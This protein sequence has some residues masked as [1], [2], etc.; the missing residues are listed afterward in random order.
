MDSRKCE[1][2]EV[3]CYLM[4]SLVF[5]VS[6]QGYVENYITGCEY[7]RE[8]DVDEYRCTN[9]GGLWTVKQKYDPVA[10]AETWQKVLD[11]LARKEVV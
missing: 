4:K 10:R 7:D 5:T 2:A 9:C 11:H 8:S 6:E 3:K 1:L